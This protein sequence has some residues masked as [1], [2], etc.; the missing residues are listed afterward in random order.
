MMRWAAA[1]C[2]G[3]AVM[4]SREQKGLDLNVYFVAEVRRVLGRAVATSV[5]VTVRPIV[6]AD[7]PALA[8]LYRRAY[9]SGSQSL[10]E[11]AAEIRSAFEGTWGVLWPEAS[12]SAWIGDELVAVVQAVHRPS[13]VSMPGAPDCPWLIDVFTDPQRRRIGLARSLIAASCRV[14][15]AAG[16]DYVGLTVDDENAPALALYRSLGF[17]KAM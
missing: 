17:Y 5:T 2:D 6:Q 11:A 8:E 9:E 14:M 3:V 12:Q 1:V 7:V 16:E 13:R 10:D 4:R 15:A